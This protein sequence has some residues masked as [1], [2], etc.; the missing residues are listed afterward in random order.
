MVVDENFHPTCLV[1]L[2]KKKPKELLLYF[3]SLS[4]SVLQKNKIGKNINV[5]V[6]FQ[7]NPNYRKAS[8]VLSHGSLIVLSLTSINCLNSFH[9]YWIKIYSEVASQSVCKTYSNTARGNWMKLTSIDIT[10]QS[11]IITYSYLRHEII[12]MYFKKYNLAIKLNFK[13]NVIFNSLFWNLYWIVLIL[14]S[15]LVF[16]RIM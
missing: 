1:D 16:Y 7:L 6:S 2:S 5:Y 13:K 14:F 10:E 3:F 4:Y 12:A 8:Y 15:S 11:H 9:M